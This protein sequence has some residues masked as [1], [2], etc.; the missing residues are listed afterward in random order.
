MNTT[1]ASIK[2]SKNLS[3][4]KFVRVHSIGKQVPENIR[5]TLRIQADMEENYN[6]NT[7]QVKGFKIFMQSEN[8][9]GVS[10]EITE[11][12][13]VTMLEFVRSEKNKIYGMDY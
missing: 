7:M 12:D 4:P 10:T 2:E 5:D 3:L 6:E 9:I 1:I 8:S 13:L 11:E